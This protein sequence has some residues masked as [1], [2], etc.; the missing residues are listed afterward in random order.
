MDY[1]R[2][3]RYSLIFFLCFSL[4][5]L[6]SGNFKVYAQGP[7]LPPSTHI[8]RLQLHTVDTGWGLLTYGEPV[9]RLLGFEVSGQD[10]SDTVHLWAPEFFEIRLDSL[11]GPFRNR[12]SLPASGQLSP[13]RIFVRLKDSLP[14][15]TYNGELLALS[16]GQ[17]GIALG[18]EP[19]VVST[20]N[21]QVLGL[22]AQNKDYDGNLQAS[23]VGQA[24]FF[25]LAFG[26]QFTPDLSGI[27]WAFASINADSGI[28]V[29]PVG[30]IPPPSLNY[31]VTPPGLQASI[32]PK[33][34]SVGGLTAQ[35]K[36]YDRGLLANVTGNAVFVGLVAGEVF[37]QPAPRTWQFE[38]KM[39]GMQ[40]SVR[41]NT[42]FTPPS[43][44]YTIDSTIL[45]ADIVPA[46]TTVQSAVVHNKIYD[47]TALASVDSVRLNGI[48]P[49][50][51]VQVLA[52]GTF[53]QFRAGNQIPVSLNI[54]LSGPDGAN[55]TAAA[56]T[57]L[58]ANITPR[59]VQITGISVA[60]KEYD[61]TRS[62][63]LLGIPQ[64]QGILSG[65]ETDAV[66]GGQPLALFATPDTGRNIPVTVSGFQLNGSAAGSYHLSQPTGL[67]GDIVLSV[68]AAWNF[69]PNHGTL[70][71]PEANVGQGSLSLIGSMSTLSWSGGMSTQ[72]G[73]G[74]AGTMSAGDTAWSIGITNPGN[75]NESGG[76]QL[77]LGSALYR[78]I[79]I[80]WDQRWSGSS[81]NTV[82]LQYSTDGIQWVN[83]QLTDSNTSYCLGRLDNG[84]FETDSTGDKFRRIRVDL[85]QITQINE[86]TVLGF[87][88]VA[89]HFRN[90]GAFRQ[91]INP[92]TT[93]TSGAWRFD[94]IRITGK[95][96]TPTVWNGVNWSQ[97]SPDTGIHAIVSAPLR[98]T[99]NLNTNRLELDSGA[100]LNVDSGA[101]LN[102]RGTFTNR[103]ILQ[104]T[105]GKAILRENYIGSGL[106]R[107]SQR[108]T[109][110]LQRQNDAGTVLMDSLSGRNAHTIE[111]LIMN[112]G[113]QGR[114]RLG[115]KMIIH[116]V[117]DLRGGV[118]QTQ[119][120][121]CLSST[122][123]T[124]TAQIRGGT[125]TS[126]QGKVDVER[127]LGWAGAGHSGYRF[128]GSPLRS[129]LPFALVGG[130][131]FTP[132]SVIRFSEP[133]NAYLSVP[134]TGNQ[135]NPAQ[136]YGI[137]TDSIRTIRLSGEPQLNQS[138]PYFLQNQSARWNL[139]GNPFPSAM[140]WDSVQKTNTENAVWVWRKDSLIPVAGI[141]AA[142]INGVGINGANGILAPLQ[143]FMVR[144]GTNGLS[145]VFFPSTARQ[146]DMTAGF[147]RQ[148]QFHPQI[149]ITLEQATP[150]F[151]EEAMIQLN[152]DA[153]SGFDIQHDA[154]Y[155]GDE[156]SV[157]PS[158]GSLDYNGY[159]YSIQSVPDPTGLARVIPLRTDLGQIG[160]CQLNIQL[161]QWP[162][163]TPIFLEDRLLQY[164]ETIVTG[165]VYS[166]Q[167]TGPA[168]SLR[169]RIH[170]NSVSSDIQED[171]LSKIQVFFH[172]GKLHIRQAGSLK[173]IELRDLNGRLIQSIFPE[174]SNELQLPLPIAQG[175]YCLT[176]HGNRSLSTRKLVR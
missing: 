4:F 59:P 88:I 67:Q 14:V 120:N 22:Q 148:N 118:L 37:S 76:I 75:I 60:E 98:I 171:D 111:T 3:S 72:N 77:M 8:P 19:A 30:S 168:D 176:L 92:S 170:L 53:H 47:R 129:S 165:M 15:G 7:P 97:G 136:A 140:A 18:I 127:H 55:Y 146:P 143:G 101:I 17:L 21:L 112:M 51:S 41:P 113:P 131:P 46:L 94:N 44:N 52:N 130:L 68:L 87:R 1:I 100:V 162:S 32:L 89:S 173:R 103:G 69:Q 20:R 73:C 90:T 163:S 175:L 85:S 154:G 25:G 107:G 86:Q 150:N 70:Q 29:A 57:G 104:L 159:A 38:N 56:P 169:F 110:E 71:H 23:V 96:A 156:S 66:L 33:R 142:Y 174:G 116:R 82:R 61:G 166:F 158:L 12:I 125:N 6:A 9:T 48:L 160:A 78:N 105:D 108:S 141:W 91:V 102:I 115:N 50:D 147:L 121:L 11:A 137:W 161:S 167:S 135:W 119:D 83:V 133:L 36:N 49:G 93:A 149:S 58:S 124:L 126:I 81:P 157:S 172:D 122:S 145:S 45:R 28:A 138:G 74:N 151:R 5:G 139:M 31:T 43:N 35:N 40:K 99:Q 64:L 114:L 62:A 84:R 39:A 34:L 134:I 95:R 128:V 152:P 42:P 2:I 123:D 132:N 24:V 13:T 106:I 80:V 117:V 63:T 79:K 26:Q 153:T 16:S 10:L 65:D 155:L 54:Q 27:S 164:I 144:A 109:L